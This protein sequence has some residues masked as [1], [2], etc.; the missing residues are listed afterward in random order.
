ME[1]LWKVLSKVICFS[2]SEDKQKLSVSFSTKKLKETWKIVDVR[3]SF[4][5]TMRKLIFLKTETETQRKVRSSYHKV[6]G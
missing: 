4:I 6:N 1:K 5:K 3:R 2:K